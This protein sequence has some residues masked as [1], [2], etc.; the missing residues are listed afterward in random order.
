MA[1]WVEACGGIRII[2]GPSDCKTERA[3]TYA[4]PKGAREKY[5]KILG[6]KLKALNER[7]DRLKKPKAKPPHPPLATESKK[8]VS[9]FEFAKGRG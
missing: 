6:K 2:V 9:F 7:R 8:K 5:K 3:S 4:P 1:A